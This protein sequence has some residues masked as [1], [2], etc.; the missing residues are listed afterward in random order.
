MI[1]VNIFFGGNLMDSREGS[2]WAVK[3][4]RFL[5]SQTKQE[6][7]LRKQFFLIV[8]FP[9]SDLCRSNTFQSRIVDGRWPMANE[10]G[11]NEKKQNA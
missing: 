3:E 4:I 11:V 1:N 9:D 6:E 10:N 5:F 8:W 7:L 2:I